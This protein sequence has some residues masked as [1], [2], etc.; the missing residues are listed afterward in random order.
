MPSSPVPPTPR[1]R[2]RLRTAAPSTPAEPRE[3]PQP[4]DQ[5]A[6]MT[7]GMLPFS[8][9][10]PETP[11]F[12]PGVP[13]TPDMTSFPGPLPRP[14]EDDDVD[15]HAQLFAPDAEGDD[16]NA[17]LNDTARHERNK[18]T[19]ADSGPTALAGPSVPVEHSSPVFE[20]ATAAGQ[21][22]SE[23]SR[24]S[25]AASLPKLPQKRPA[26]ALCSTGAFKFFVDSFGEAVLEKRGEADDIR[27][28]FRRQPFYRSYLGSHARKLEMAK[29]N[30]H[31][32]PGREDASSDDES[33]TN[34]QQPHA[35]PPG[36]QA[37]GPRTALE[38]D[39][40][41]PSCLLREVPGVSQGRGEQLAELG[42]H[43]TP[44]S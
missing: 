37:T 9:G 28:P 17:E 32:D 22:A 16:A 18:A 30:I 35:L 24:P 21:L 40:Q 44:F 8:P 12:S 20:P 6:P 25:Q 43:T 7:P 29:H 23:S 36:A 5:A 38:R 14:Q 10:I 3:A 11:P 34:F 42:R 39:R 2:A 27:P 33:L 31:D 41:P 19:K 13:G 15:L 4:E 26:D 1:S